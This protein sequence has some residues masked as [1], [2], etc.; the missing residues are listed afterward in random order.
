VV[1]TPA[2]KEKMFNSGNDIAAGTPDDLRNH[3]KSEI[4]RLTKV[5]KDANI[6]LD[7]K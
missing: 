4:A 3:M 2:V 5:I 1:N 7:G 6:K